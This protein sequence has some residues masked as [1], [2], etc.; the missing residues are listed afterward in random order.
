[1]QHLEERVKDGI[2]IPTLDCKMP[3]KL[4]TIDA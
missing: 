2:L 4:K 1:V 3:L